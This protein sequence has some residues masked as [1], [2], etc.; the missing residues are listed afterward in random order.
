[1]KAGRSTHPIVCPNR[2]ILHIQAR[3]RRMRL[4]PW[5]MVE[6]ERRVRT[7]RWF[8]TALHPVSRRLRLSA[9]TK[10]RSPGSSVLSHLG[11]SS[12]EPSRLPAMCRGSRLRAKACI[13]FSQPRHPHP[14]TVPSRLSSPTPTS[15]SPLNHSH[16]HP[17]PEAPKS[18]WWTRP[19]AVPT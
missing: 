17:T 15:T 9:G 7:G 13:R 16:F 18:R 19:N 2:Y 1:M 11:I 4:R 10:R 5:S 12:I 8:Y 6:T 3:Q 14:P